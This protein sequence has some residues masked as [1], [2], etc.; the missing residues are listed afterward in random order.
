MFRN[1]REF[2]F[3]TVEMFVGSKHLRHTIN[4]TNRHLYFATNPKPIIPPFFPFNKFINIF[5]IQIQSL[6]SIILKT[7]TKHGYQYTKET[8]YIQFQSYLIQ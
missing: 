8:K 6:N 4:K 2:C 7:R 1:D 3:V 5:S